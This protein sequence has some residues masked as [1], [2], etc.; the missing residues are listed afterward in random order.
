M[1]GEVNRSLAYLQRLEKKIV[2]L[3]EIPESGHFP[4][5]SNRSKCTVELQNSLHSMM[6][7]AKKL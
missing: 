4:M 3:A 6:K 7:W 5:D 2:E 1:F